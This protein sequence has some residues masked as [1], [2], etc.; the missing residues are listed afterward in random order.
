MADDVVETQTEDPEPEGVVEVDVAA[1]GVKQKMVPVSV[2]PAERRRIREVEVAKRQVIEQKLQQAEQENTR[3]KQVEADLQAVRPHIEQLQ[4]TQQRAGETPEMAAISDEEAKAFALEMELYTA[5]GPDVTRARRIIAKNQKQIREAATAAAREAVAP[6][7]Q[8]AAYNQSAAF[9][10]WALNQRGP[11]GAA[12]ADPDILREV[13]ANTPSHLTQDPVVARD[14]LEV[15]IG[16]TLLAGK[17][18]AA[19]PQRE[20]MFTESPGGYR[21][22]VYEMTPMERTIQQNHGISEKDWTET[23]KR[24]VPGRTNRL[25]E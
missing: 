8:S 12:L 4:R 13:W 9:L 7:A 1:A 10:S 22:R 20:P 14:R 5:T 21:E 19:P 24:Y 18:P 11:D 2:L 15:A 17:K 6:L 16:K 25:G 3:L 23:A